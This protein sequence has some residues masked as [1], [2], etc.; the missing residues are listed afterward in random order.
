MDRVGK[1]LAAQSE[2]IL[3]VSSR[4]SGP[5]TPVAELW[6]VNTEMLAPVV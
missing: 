3:E 6:Q 2:R 1:L 5:L 4:L